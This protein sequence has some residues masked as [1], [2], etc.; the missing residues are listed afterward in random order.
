MSN[1]KGGPPAAGPPHA[2]K[3][4]SRPE[5]P[6]S[7]RSE[8]PGSPDSELPGSP[9]SERV[10]LPDSAAASPL[11]RAGV[12]WQAD[13]DPDP[14]HADSTLPASETLSG[15]EPLDEADDLAV[16]PDPIAD[17]D[18]E[19]SEALTDVPTRTARATA[20]LSATESPSGST[21][22]SKEVRPRSQTIARKQMLRERRRLIAQGG[23][24]E[25]VDYERPKHRSDCRDG[26]RPCL[27]VACRYHLFL[28]V[29]PMT[30]SIKINFPDLP[31]WQLEETCALDVAERGGVT[32]EEV[33]D[34][35]NL[36]RERIRQVEA[37]GLGKLRTGEASLSSFLDGSDIVVGGPGTSGHHRLLVL[38]D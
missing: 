33:G 28:D 5:E 27:Y 22:A 1:E 4:S 38:D 37:T 24:P 21:E 3:S 13:I 2:S 10:G 11:D 15:I 8:G 17:E 26:R 31:V 18:E 12:E 14:W 30:G 36:T 16:S 29:N 35:M 7:P 20:S 25:V 9:R 23:L 6:R 19:D 32:L 34:I